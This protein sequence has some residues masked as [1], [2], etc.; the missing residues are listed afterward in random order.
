[1]LNLSIILLSYFH[2]QQ[3]NVLTP[4]L[5]LCDGDFEE[6]MNNDDLPDFRCAS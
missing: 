3:D 4:N 5:R 2:V 6:E 1:M